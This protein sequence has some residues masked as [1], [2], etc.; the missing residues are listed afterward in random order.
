[1]AVFFRVGLATA[2]DVFGLYGRRGRFEY[3]TQASANDWQGVGQR[4][5]LDFIYKL[6]KIRSGYGVK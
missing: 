6:E 3:M 4:I 5:K 2:Q 1:M